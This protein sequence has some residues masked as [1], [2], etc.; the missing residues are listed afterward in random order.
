MI[1][2]VATENVCPFDGALFALFRSSRF[3]DRKVY[4]TGVTKETSV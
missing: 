4:S 3:W 2:V 1:Y